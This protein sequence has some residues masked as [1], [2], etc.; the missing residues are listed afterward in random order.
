MDV[1]RVI[2]RSNNVSYI[3][4]KISI[5]L[6]KAPTHLVFLP[7]NQ[8]KKSISVTNKKLGI[9]QRSVHKSNRFDVPKPLF[10]FKMA[11]FFYLY[12]WRKCDPQLLVLSRFV[13]KK[14]CAQD[15]N[16]Y[17]TWSILNEIDRFTLEFW[18]KLLWASRGM[19]LI[20]PFCFFFFDRG[21]LRLI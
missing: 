11:F 20:T 15:I 17:Y 19:V 1:S 3:R 10:M 7:K 18:D 5:L 4:F 9:S 6:G 21:K 14:T 16:T 8:V 13:N 2:N 12:Y